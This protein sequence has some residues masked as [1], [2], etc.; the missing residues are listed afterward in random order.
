MRLLS[1]RLHPF[2]RFV[3]QTWDLQSPLVVIHG[4]NELGKSTLRQAITHALFTPTNLTKGA[5]KSEIEPHLPRPDGDHARVTLTLQQ[6]DTTW[7]VEK[8]WGAG[9][10]SRLTDGVTSIADP[11]SVQRTLQGFVSHSKAT[12]DYILFTGQAELEQTLTDLRKQPDGLRDVRDLL[13]SAGGAAGDVDEEKLRELIQDRVDKA[14]GRWDDERGRPQ[15]QNGKE[16]GINDRWQK[17]VGGILKAWYEWQTLVTEHDEILRLEREVD[18]VNANTASLREKTAQAEALVREHGHLHEDAT[19]RGKLEERV[20]RLE[21]NLAGLNHALASWQSTRSEMERWPMLKASLEDRIQGLVRERENAERRGQAHSLRVDFARLA[22]AKAEAEAAQIAVDQI[23]GPTEQ[24]AQVMA[25]LQTE[26]SNLEI[27]AAASELRWSIES[28]TPSAVGVERHGSLETLQVG[29]QPLEGVAEGRVRLLVGDIS[30]TVTSSE[31]DKTSLAEAL[32]A[33]QLELSELLSVCGLS[34]TTDIA[35][36]LVERRDAEATAG[37]KWAVLNGLLGAR[38]FA[39]WKALV[40]EIDALPDARE[41]PIVEGEL[42]A[43]RDEL[44]RGTARMENHTASVEDW[45]VRYQDLEHFEAEVK[46]I[47]DELHI[48]KA[49]LEGLALIPAPFDSPESFLAALNDAQATQNASQEAQAG[50]REQLAALNAILGDR[51]SQDVGDDAEL[52]QRLFARARSQGQSFK[53][54][55]AVLNQVAA[56]GASDPL[57]GL[58]GQVSKLFARIT[59]T[60]TNLRFEGP[61]PAEVVRGRVALPPERLSHGAG[62]ALALALR[63]AMAH[64]YLASGGGIVMLDDPLVHF[65]AQR[66]RS[67][68]EVVREFSNTAQVIYFTCHDHHAEQLSA[69]T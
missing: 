42:N 8:C 46:R 60:E 5:L 19:R 4:P 28:P 61:L 3:D 33:R 69:R 2:G 62:G 56:D 68:A 63:L 17:E 57:L 30:F 29:P 44:T 41:I 11:D 64:A 12:Y 59:G 65:D 31:G 50:L 27:R 24:Q 10:G 6:D 13:R 23:A 48:G 22:E 9:G 55:L 67:A 52:A 45:Q 16:K 1:V 36:Q 14:F 51:R 18:R 47:A 43:V 66:M 38:S 58:E 15:Q 34:T 39:E 21:Q 35:A 25:A 49:E 20:L 7:T 32:A 53:R 40:A 26:I 54:I 37:S